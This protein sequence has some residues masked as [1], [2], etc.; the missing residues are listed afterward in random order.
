MIGI[1]QY[2]SGQKYEGELL[3]AENKLEKHGKGKFFGCK[4]TLFY[5]GEWVHDMREGAGTMYFSNGYRY[6]GEWLRNAKHGKGI[7]Y[8]IN[9]NEAYNG[10][11]KN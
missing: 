2:E 9:N 6:E 4:G 5:D 3:N 10:T 7:L 11:F 1:I 8:D